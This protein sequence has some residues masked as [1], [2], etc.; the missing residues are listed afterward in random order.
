M[1]GV[2]TEPQV[3]PFS[4]VFTCLSFFSFSFLLRHSSQACDLPALSSEAVGLQVC[5][6]TA[7]LSHPLSRSILRIEDRGT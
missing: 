5:A 2:K 1:S 7:G 6:T 3:K 4:S